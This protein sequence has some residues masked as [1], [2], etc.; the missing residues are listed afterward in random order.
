MEGFNRLTF[1]SLNNNKKKQ[2]CD[3]AFGIEFN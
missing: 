3:Q 1:S 2:Q